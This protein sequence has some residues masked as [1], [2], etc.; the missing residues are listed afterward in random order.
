MKLFF[1]NILLVI[2]QKHLM[3]IG[4]YCKHVFISFF[5]VCKNLNKKNIKFKI[6][7]GVIFL[8]PSIF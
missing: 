8:L 3:I 4:E 7:G 1:Y 5:D 6:G 2:L